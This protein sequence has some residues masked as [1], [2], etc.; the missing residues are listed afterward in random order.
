MLQ[1]AGLSLSLKII[2]LLLETMAPKIKAV[3]SN[4]LDVLIVIIFFL[5]IFIIFAGGFSII[6]A[7][8]EVSATSVH[9]P[10]GILL[11]LY[12]VKLFVADFKKELEKNK[13]LAIGTLLMMMLFSEF[14]ARVY[15]HFFVPQ[16]LFWA[17]ENLLMKRTADPGH[18][19]VV[20]TVRVSKNKKITYELVPGIRGYV[21]IWPKDKH[22]NVN[23]LGFRDDEEKS[24]TKEKGTF[25]ILGI[26]DS[27]MMGQG[28]SFND[29]Y[30]EVLENELNQKAQGNNMDM[31][32]EFINLAVHGYNTTME[33]ETFFEKGLK[34]SPDM[35]II[36]YVPNDFDLP[37]FIIKKENPWV[38]KK[39]FA[40][41]FINKR[42]EAFANTKYGKFLGNATWEN[43]KKDLGLWGLD[44]AMWRNDKYGNPIGNKYTFVPDD[45]KSMVGIEAYV[46]E[47]KRLKKKCDELNIPLILQFDV[48]EDKVIENRERIPIETAG[49]LNI[50]VVKNYEEVREY[51]KKYEN[52]PEY[53]CVLSSKWP[54]D[55]EERKEIRA[56]ISTDSDCH[57]NKWGHLLIGK[58]LASFIYAN[59][60]SPN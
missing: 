5:I 24:Y 59:Y 40:V 2:L 52:D 55:E 57:P 58:K 20:D 49:E 44:M 25:R 60:L 27:V 45:Y 8:H 12:I 28:V 42:M 47:L 4:V 36:S 35:V 15:Y 9:K 30:G 23:R 3:V 51:L 38:S 34:F 46:R 21:E 13:A 22:L 39:S 14:S 37:N 11:V 6:I 53:I 50:P 16:D 56:R 33:V 19:Y 29:T 32:V 1:F 54:I 10:A 26:G 7:G 43:Q 17:T 48:P 31:K 18:M 41:F